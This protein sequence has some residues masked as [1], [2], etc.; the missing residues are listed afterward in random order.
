MTTQYGFYHNNDECVGCKAC[1]IAC[2]DKNDLPLGEKYRRVYDYGGGQWEVD[3]SGAVTPRDFFVYSVSVACM[4]CAAPACITSCPVGAIIKREDGIVF[5]DA[6][7]CIGCGS[8]VAACPFSAPY[9]SEATGAAQKCDFCKDLIDEGELP[10]CVSACPMRCLNYGELEELQSAHGAVD[11]VD[12]LPKNA[13]TGPSIVFT[14]SRLNPDGQLVGEIL[15][16]P[17]EL[18]SATVQGSTM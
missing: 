9:M 18:E 7:T 4:H 2:K 5:I 8:C 10:V 3:E 16:S 6:Q 14:R 11:Q 1:V 15:N 12:P 13:G 17:E